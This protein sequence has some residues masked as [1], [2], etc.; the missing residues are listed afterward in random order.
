MKLALGFF[1]FN[2]LVHKKLKLER[3]LK[4]YASPMQFRFDVAVRDI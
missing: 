3:P 2:L 1:A 4:K